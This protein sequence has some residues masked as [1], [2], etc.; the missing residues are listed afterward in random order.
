MSRL[1][2]DD[3]EWDAWDNSTQ[4]DNELD[5]MNEGLS[6]SR[7]GARRG[8][9]AETEEDSELNVVIKQL[10]TFQMNLADSLVIAKCN[11]QLMI[12][13]DHFIRYYRSENRRSELAVLTIKN[14]LSR[15]AYTVTYQGEKFTSEE[16]IVKVY[17][18]TEEEEIWSLAN[19]SIYGDILQVLQTFFLDPTLAITISNSDSEFHINLDSKVVSSKNKFSLGCNQEIELATLEAAITVNLGTKECLQ[20]LSSPELPFI[21]DEDIRSAAASVV[22]MNR[23]YQPQGDRGGTDKKGSLLDIDTARAKLLEGSNLLLDA[24][25]LTGNFITG[26]DLSESS[27]VESLRGLAVQYLGNGQ[28]QQIEGDDI[29]DGNEGNNDSGRKSHG[30]L[31]GTVNRIGRGLVFQVGNLLGAES[32]EDDAEEPLT[33]YRK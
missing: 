29:L 8:Q 28:H 9:K 17:H 18:L 10:K 26:E 33:L 25:V 32:N 2:L 13:F 24:A 31:F 6:G 16:E 23:I 21:F 19:Q 20:H 14:E 12:E 1:P 22:E 7:N 3:D 30:G 15:M 11:R 4:E 27:V 5:E